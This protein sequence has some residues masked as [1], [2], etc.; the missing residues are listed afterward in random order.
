[1]SMKRR[2][3]IKLLI[4]AGALPLISK[5]TVARAQSGENI[6]IIGAG[7]AGLAAGRMLAEN[8]YTVRIIEARE[9][10]GGRVWTDRTLN[11][12]PLDMGA[13]W[14]HGI[15]GN[16]ITDL[17]KQLGDPRL[18]TDYENIVVYTADG[19]EIDEDTLEEYAEIFT[20]LLE[21]IADE[22]EDLDT[23][24]SLGSALRAWA[25]DEELDDEEIAA[26]NFVVN[27]VIEHEYAADV[28]K[29][30]VWNW[31]ASDGFGGDDVLLP[32]GYQRLANALALTLP[33][34]TGEV[35]QS[36]TLDGNEVIV[37]TN[38]NTLRADRVIVTVPLGVLKAGHINF[39]PPLPSRKQTAID[40]LHMGVLNKVYV[41]FPSVFWDEDVDLIGHIDEDTKGRWGEFLNIYKYTGETIL[42]GFNAGTYGK[43]IESWT[44]AEIIEDMLDVLQSIYDGVPAPL[45]YRI[46]RWGQDP[47]TLGSYT[48]M[49]VGATP[50]DCR[51][52]AQ[53]ISERIFF[54]GEA[55]NSEYIGTGH[56][57]F[58][59]GQRAAEEIMEG[60]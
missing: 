51:N 44:D 7:M 58:L 55:T 48:S 24:V 1:M 28:N 20:E 37:Q 15:R 60:D 29:L 35:V 6:I 11:D 18:T 56:G 21:T 8:G 12:I 54:A 43:R 27:S 59:S 47:Y 50:Q 22:A 53:S 14:I 38:K 57:A 33:I 3:F 52:L 5:S 49:G 10:I 13:S 34:S 26:L 36:I 25:D 31:N 42:L 46:T 23:D 45:D 9:R 16:P 32:M 19:D 41:R 39:I 4:L 2:D 17:A 30:S 40:R